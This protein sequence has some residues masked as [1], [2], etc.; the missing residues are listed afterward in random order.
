MLRGLVGEFNIM[1]RNNLQEKFSFVV[2]VSLLAPPLISFLFAK[3]RNSE[4]CCFGE[5][6]LYKLHSILYGW[7]A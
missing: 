7:D 6:K 2:F 3:R 4:I 5:V 1:E